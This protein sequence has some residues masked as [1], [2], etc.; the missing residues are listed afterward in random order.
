VAFA[1]IPPRVES[2]LVIPRGVPGSG[3]PATTTVMD[4]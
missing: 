2:V 3:R 1:A 4:A